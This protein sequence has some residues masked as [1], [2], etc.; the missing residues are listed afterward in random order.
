MFV[1]SVKRNRK[2]LKELNTGIYE[3]LSFELVK[4]A[5]NNETEQIKQ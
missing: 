1:L 3:C 5:E 2:L 4:N